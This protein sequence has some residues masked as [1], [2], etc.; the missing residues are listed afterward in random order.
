MARLALAADERAVGVVRELEAHVEQARGASVGAHASFDGVGMTDRRGELAVGE[1]E[2]VVARGAGGERLAP[3][4]DQ[5]ERA[6]E[7]VD[8]RER[9]AGRAGG[10]VDRRVGA[11]DDRERPVAPRRHLAERSPRELEAR[12]A[13][14]EGRS[15]RRSARSRRTPCAARRA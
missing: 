5:G 3:D 7:G 8:D 12:L 6:R 10:E 14:R 15:N 2:G 1:I 13:L 11:K 9:A 4:R